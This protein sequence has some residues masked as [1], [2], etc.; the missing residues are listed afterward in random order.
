MQVPGQHIIFIH[1]SRD[2]SHWAASADLTVRKMITQD[3][4]DLFLSSFSTS[5]PVEMT[6]TLPEALIRTPL[7]WPSTEELLL[8][9]GA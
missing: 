4:R 3:D 9:E 8:R 5:S 6:P 2:Y 7:R 1:S